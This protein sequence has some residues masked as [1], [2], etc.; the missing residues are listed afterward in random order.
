MTATNTGAPAVGSANGAVAATP[1]AKALAES[2]VDL[3]EMIRDGVPEPTFVPGCEPWLRR[4]KRYLSFGPAGDGKSLAWLVVAVTAVEAG[5]KVVILDVENGCEEYAARLADVL[6]ARDPD[7][8]LSDAVQERLS[9]HAWPSLSL[10]WKAE[11]WAAAIDGAEL[12]IF[13]SSRMVLTSI[14]VGEDKSDDYAKFVDGL[15]IPLSKSGTTT[16]VLD[17][18]SHA[19]PSRTRGTITKTD[20]NEVAYRLVV[21]APFD[22]ERT[23]T[24]RLI[25][26]RTRFSGLPA[27]L[28]IDLG[29]GVYS[30]PVVPDAIGAPVPVD[31]RPTRLMERFSRA[32]EATPGMSQN[33]LLREVKGGKQVAKIQAIR[34]LILEGYVRSET[35]GQAGRHHSIEPYREADDDRA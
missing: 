27:E 29:G 34:A 12:V 18:T 6:D 16:V 15:L 25:R 9:Y 17:N 20:L 14:G 1:P 26:R 30:A 35:V 21:G 32:I 10:G 4:G 24:V 22:R 31:F 3:V 33:G 11:D 13:D 23:G 19:D 2:R 8:S 28:R 7:G 5:A